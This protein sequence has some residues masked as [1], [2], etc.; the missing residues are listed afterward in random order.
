MVVTNDVVRGNVLE[1]TVTW[2]FL[3]LGTYNPLTNSGEFTAM[4]WVKTVETPS[5]DWQPL[6]MKR[7]SS[8]ANTFFQF[9][10][11]DTSASGAGRLRIEDD[12]QSVDSPLGIAVWT[13]WVHYAFSA[14]IMDSINCPNRITVQ[15][16]KN[17][18]ALTGGTSVLDLDPADAG[19]P[20][21]VA[22]TFTDKTHAVPGARYD[23]IR[24]YDQALTAEQIRE[25]A[26]IP[27]LTASIAV[28]DGTVTVSWDSMIGYGYQLQ[29]TTNLASLSW[30]N[31]GDP[32]IATATHSSASEAAGVDPTF[33]RVQ[34]LP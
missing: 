34:M 20:I 4:L 9:D 16:F 29:K 33:Y 17:G 11:W 25:I 6:I 5:L 19:Q 31:V 12:N 28:A 14:K 21:I 32:V 22:N 24:F 27:L 26:G 3:N 18:R 7:G 30:T 10:V 8:F 2:A 1:Q 23:D 15:L 13:N